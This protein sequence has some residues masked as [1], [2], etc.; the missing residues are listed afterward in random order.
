M[1][2]FP[3]FSFDIVIIRN[4]EIS[5][6]KHVLDSVCVFF[7]LFGGVGGLPRGPAHNLFTQFFLAWAAQKWIFPKLVFLGF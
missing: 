2:S 1:E 3:K 5:Y 4:E 7:T 6:V